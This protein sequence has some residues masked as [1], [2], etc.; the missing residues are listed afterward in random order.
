MR[1]GTDIGGGMLVTEFRV[2]QY[3]YLKGKRTYTLPLDYMVSHLT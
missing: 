3:M 2:N 1:C